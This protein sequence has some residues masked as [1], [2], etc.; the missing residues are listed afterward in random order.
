[1]TDH[2]IPGIHTAMGKRP[3]IDGKMMAIIETVSATIGEQSLA[4]SAIIKQMLLEL[5]RSQDPQNLAHINA[6]HV[7]VTLHVVEHLAK[8]LGVTPQ[9]A[10]ASVANDLRRELAQ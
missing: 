4:S 5:F 1:M 3:D 6:A 7:R 9:E 8:A 2:V 10:W